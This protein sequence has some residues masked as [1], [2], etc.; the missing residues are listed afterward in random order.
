M[1]S[2]QQHI[3][4][5]TANYHETRRCWMPKIANKKG[6]NISTMIKHCKHRL[7]CLG[8][9]SHRPSLQHKKG[10]QLTNKL[11]FVVIHEIIIQKKY[12]LRY[13]K[14]LRFQHTCIFFKTLHY[15]YIWNN[16][17]QSCLHTDRKWR[18]HPASHMSLWSRWENWPLQGSRML[19]HGSEVWCLFWLVKRLQMIR[20]GN[21]LMLQIVGY[22]KYR[23]I[24]RLLCCY[25][26]Y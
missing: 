10:N 21:S 13:W 24:Y 17:G 20:R 14:Q 2:R 12:F 9:W 22:T 8:F 15:N 11:G 6:L 18:P 26:L 1:W 7:Y 25:Y 5:A 4:K 16:K 19:I 23:K 3:S